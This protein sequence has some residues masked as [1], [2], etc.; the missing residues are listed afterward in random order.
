[1]IIVSNNITEKTKTK[2]RTNDSAE[3]CLSADI[4]A[5]TSALCCAL[6][7]TYLFIFVWFSA[8]PL[9]LSDNDVYSCCHGY[10]TDGILVLDTI[11]SATKGFTAQ[12]FRRPSCNP[13]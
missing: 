6:L 7:Y 13:K 5:V 4:S 1:M 2:G 12:N 11:E 9:P 10:G 8:R 3:W